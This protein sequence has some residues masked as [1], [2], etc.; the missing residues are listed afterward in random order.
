MAFLLTALKDKYVAMRGFHTKRRLALIE[1]DDWG[2]IRMPSKQV[3]EQLQ[4]AGDHPEHDAFLRND[5]LESEKDLIN[6]FE[7]LSSVKDSKGRPAIMTANFATAN[8]D[9]DRIDYQNGHYAYEPF[10]ETYQRYYPESSHLTLIADAIGKGTFCPQLHCREHV[11]VNRW[12]RDLQRGK[13]DTLLAFEHRMIGVGASFSSDNTFGYMDAFHTDCETDPQHLADVL[14]EAA[15]IFEKAFGYRSQTFVASCFVWHPSLE[16]HLLKEGVKGVQSAKWQNLPSGRCGEYSLHRKLR[17]TGQRNRQGQIYTVRN[18]DYEPAY[19]Q[20]PAECAARCLEMV[21]KSFREGKPAIINSHR[22][23]YIST[24]NPLNA[25]N[26][27]KGLQWLL[28]QIADAFPDVEFI[29]T[30]ELIDICSQEK[31]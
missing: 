23:N 28:S 1:S 13:A 21:K 12:M 14:H 8:P 11:N 3:L 7:V 2:S 30:P 20:N 27:L 10:Y 25:E 19:Y 31:K 5:C 15:E 17:F 22:F 29:S 6:L 4:A 9:F 18:C 24:I 26:N 16:R